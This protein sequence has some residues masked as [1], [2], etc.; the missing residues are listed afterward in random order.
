MPNISLKPNLLDPERGR[1]LQS[2]EE[3][4]GS[5]LVLCM[6]THNGLGVF[7]GHI[8]GNQKN[9]RM[10]PG[11]T[12]WLAPLSLILSLSASAL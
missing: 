2:H 5:D 7:L 6:Q 1:V 9:E 3:S 8:K 4:W 12:L 11:P 10:A